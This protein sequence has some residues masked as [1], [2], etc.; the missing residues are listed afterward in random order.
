MVGAHLVYSIIFMYISKA[1]SWAMYLG[2]G[3]DF[4][5]MMPSCF[6][7]K[8]WGRWESTR[9]IPTYTSYI[10]VIFHG[11]MGENMVFHVLGS[12]LRSG[13][14]PSVPISQALVASLRMPL[15][16]KTKREVVG[17]PGI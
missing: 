16:F 11:F 17:Q 14:F 6:T 2:A 10:W 12:Q 8:S 1:S 4:L 13:T 7:E 15:A 3:G 9:D 5:H